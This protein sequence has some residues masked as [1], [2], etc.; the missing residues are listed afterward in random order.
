MPPLSP[1]M[2]APPAE[3]RL[4]SRTAAKQREAAHS[5]SFSQSLSHDEEIEALRFHFMKKRSQRSIASNS[6]KASALS[7]RTL[8]NSDLVHSF[9][10]K[11][12]SVSDLEELFKKKQSLTLDE[13]ITMKKEQSLRFDER[14]ALKKKAN[15]KYDTSMVL[16]K[17]KDD[18]SNRKLR[19]KSSPR[20]IDSFIEE[21]DLNSDDETIPDCVSVDSIPF[22]YQDASSVVDAYDKKVAAAAKKDQILKKLTLFEEKIQ[23]KIDQEA[24]G[25]AATKGR[26]RKAI[27]SGPRRRSV[28]APHPG[29]D[30]R[31][32]KD[33]KDRGI[34]ADAETNTPILDNCFKRLHMS[35]EERV[36]AKIAKEM[37]TNSTVNRRRSINAPCP[38]IVQVNRPSSSPKG[39]INKAKEDSMDSALDS[40]ES[41]LKN[42]LSQG[43]TRPSP[44]RT[45]P[46][47]DL[48][49]KSQSEKAFNKHALPRKETSITEGGS[50]ETWQC[51]K[52]TYT[53]TSSTS[54][55]CRMCVK[56]IVSSYESSGSTNSKMQGDATKSRRKLTRASQS[57][58]N[59]NSSAIRLKNMGV[60]HKTTSMSKSVNAGAS[61]LK[62]SCGKCSYSNDAIS[63]ECKMCL[64]PVKNELN[65][66][67][68]DSAIHEAI[69]ISLKDT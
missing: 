28:S 14:V 22:S 27:S 42:K 33:A 60:S 13:R 58:R 40:F 24:A 21:E 9:E 59:L 67:D 39:H 32:L 37:E 20:S 65:W 66:K 62:W 34:S 53:S 56:P 46:K 15:K 4:K 52:N 5:R 6:L 23:R 26:R 1:E 7:N 31:K 41:R 47:R 25:N 57:E 16:T 8:Q 11:N 30:M 29:I 49:A 19:R 69:S 55:L 12:A 45:L 48:P 2:M 43:S 68:L 10:E 61:A 17:T 18:S 54:G 44:S 64:E 51:P 36:H 50:V 35:H 63:K 38:G 3:S